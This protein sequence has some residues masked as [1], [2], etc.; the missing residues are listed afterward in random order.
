M[1]APGLA[2]LRPV[3]APRRKPKI[4]IAVVLLNAAR[5]LGETLEPR[6]V[7]VRFHEL[8]ADVIPH[9]ALVVSSY[10]PRDDLIRCQYGWNEGTVLDPATLPPL[11]LNR[12]GGDA[13]PGDRQRGAA[14][15][16]RRRRAGRAA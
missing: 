2:T 1:T 12:E 13:E 16:Q 4:E 6:R 3:R 5:E 7:Y 8:L 11:P 14:P 9:D 10:D 15:V